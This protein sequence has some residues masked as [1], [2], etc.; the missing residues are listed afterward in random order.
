MLT[1]YQAYNMFVSNNNKNI[2]NLR[3]RTIPY[4]LTTTVPN[5]LNSVAVNQDIVFRKVHKD[6]K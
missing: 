5:Q 1:T 6:R 2:L 3:V 4:Q